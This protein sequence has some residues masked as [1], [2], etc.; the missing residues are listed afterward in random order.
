MTMSSAAKFTQAAA[1]KDQL[2][3]PETMHGHRHQ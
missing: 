1:A 2:A 3:S